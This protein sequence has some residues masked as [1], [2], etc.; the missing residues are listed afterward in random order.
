MGD[1]NDNGP[2]PEEPA[3][4]AETNP[5]QGAKTATTTS[6]EGQSLNRKRGEEPKKRSD[7]ASLLF[8][9]FFYLVIGLI[10]I[11][12]S[13]QTQNFLL[14]NRLPLGIIAALAFVA[15]GVAWF[16]RDMLE[17]SAKRKIALIIF[18]SIPILLALLGAV[19]LLGATYQIALLRS[20]FLLIVCLLPATMYYLFIASRKSSLLQEYFTNLARLGLFDLQTVGGSGCKANFESELERR[21]RVMSYIQKFEAAYGQIPVELA[22][23]ILEATTP[24]AI[25]PKVPPFDKYATGGTLG[26][27]FTP[28]TAIPVVLTTLLIGLGWLLTLPPWGIIDFPQNA[29][30]NLYLKYVLQPQETTVYFA[31]LGAYFFSL[32]ML[33]RRFVRKDLRAN[34]YIAVSMRIILAVLGTW[35]VLQA[36]A[37]LKI[38]FQAD[39]SEHQALLIV[40]FV[41]GAFPPVAWQVIQAAFRTLTGAKYLVPSLNSDMPVSDLDGLTVW[42]EARLEEEDIENIPNMATADIVELMLNTRIPPNR[43]VDWVDQAM[44]YTH[45]GPD[46]QLEKNGNAQGIAKNCRQRLREH[47]I[48]TASDLVAAYEKSAQRQDIALFEELLPGQGRSRIRSLVDTLSIN[49]N[50]LIVQ[51]WQ[52]QCGQAPWQKTL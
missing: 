15:V 2:L 10:W 37:F 46:K 1:G 43:I 21:V 49:P 52:W 39:G 25:H 23:D 7:F 40:G 6:A 24:D 35:T 32:Q 26:A 16:R 5:A 20:V 47:G 30:I 22:G 48:R 13:P 18:V 17:A 38:P 50:L 8:G 27:V 9:L 11:W 42:H 12:N 41:I 19:L 3:G 28:E 51:R 14:R 36:A 45:L 44:L 29:S 31:F 4:A 33:F 34:A